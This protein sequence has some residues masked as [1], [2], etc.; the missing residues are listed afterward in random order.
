MNERAKEQRNA[1]MKE[2]RKR[3]KEKVKAAQEK[4]WEKKF[5]EKEKESVS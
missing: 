3:N 5:K 4:Y 1:Y 2:W